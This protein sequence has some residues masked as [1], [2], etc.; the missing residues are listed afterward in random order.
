MPLLDSQR[1]HSSATPRRDNIRAPTP[2]SSS[3]LVSSWSEAGIG[4]DLAVFT[5]T[6]RS[7]PWKTKLATKSTK[8][9]TVHSN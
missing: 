8:Y 4:T 1:P 7:P 3:I 2:V 6:R 5:P 9:E